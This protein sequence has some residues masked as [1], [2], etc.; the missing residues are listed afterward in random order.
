MSGER[1]PSWRMS[2]SLERVVAVAGPYECFGSRAM[3]GGEYGL[4][5][6]R[7]ATAAECDGFQ[8]HVFVGGICHGCGA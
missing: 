8:G 1:L 2:A 6:P 7:L 5:F 3:D 4:V